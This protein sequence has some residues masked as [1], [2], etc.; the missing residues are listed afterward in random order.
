MVHFVYIPNGFY[1]V[2]FKR[3]VPFKTATRYIQKAK[4]VRRSTCISPL[5]A[6]IQKILTNHY[7][8]A[9]QRT[10]SVVHAQK[11][12]IAVLL[13]EGATNFESVVKSN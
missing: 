8:D 9:R 1:R 6:K 2:D 4:K 13:Y 12:L 3:F 10:S 11:N 5:E 7:Y